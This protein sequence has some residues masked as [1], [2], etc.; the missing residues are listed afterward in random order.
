MKRNEKKRK[1]KEIN[2]KGMKLIKGNEKEMKL[3]EMKRR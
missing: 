1:Q 3:K 2:E